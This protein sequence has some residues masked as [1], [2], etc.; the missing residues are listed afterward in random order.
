M[1]YTRHEAE[2]KALMQAAWAIAAAARTAPKARGGDRLEVMVIDGEEK[3]HLSDAMRKLA[4]D[5]QQPFFS[6]DA[7]GVD[8][9]LVVIL[10]GIRNEEAGVPACG[11]CGFSD[12]EDKRTNRGVCAVG[13][14]DLGI[15]AGSAV[16]LAADLRC[17]NRIL[18]SGGKAAIELNW[19]PEEVVVAYAIPLSLSGKSPFFDRG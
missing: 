11:F 16:S 9:S 3:N 7:D 1:M 8:Q 14:T 2:N 6:R 15:A 10:M 13:V 4:G 12:C 5:S 18:F 19:F 17:D